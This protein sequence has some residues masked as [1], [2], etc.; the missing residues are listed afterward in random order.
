MYTLLYESKMLMHDSDDMTY[1]EYSRKVRIVLK[2]SAPL[3]ETSCLQIFNSKLTS[4]ICLQ[5][6]D[7]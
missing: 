7:S 6:E 4:Y 2:K 3:F 1:T 5:R